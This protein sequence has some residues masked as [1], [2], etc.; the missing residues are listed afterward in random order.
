MVLCAFVHINTLRLLSQSCFIKVWRQVN[1]DRVA[2]SLR[3]ESHSNELKSHCS[4]VIIQAVINRCWRTTNHTVQTQSPIKPLF[5]SARTHTY[6]HTH[7]KGLETCGTTCLNTLAEKE[8]T[9]QLRNQLF[10]RWC[11][12]CHNTLFT[13]SNTHTHAQPTQGRYHSY[14]R[15]R[16]V[17]IMSVFSP[18]PLETDQQVCLCVY[19]FGSCVGFAVIKWSTNIS[20]VCNTNDRHH[21]CSQKEC[22]LLTFHL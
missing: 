22:I 1:V 20:T 12:C 5:R 10:L 9:N 17:L 7:L 4:R 3:C 14:N 19:L 16:L 6:I 2:S 18:K 8:I 15:N 11:H 21:N 13:P